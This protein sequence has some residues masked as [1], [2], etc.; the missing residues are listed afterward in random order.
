MEE[1][2]P[3]ACCVVLLALWFWASSLAHDAAER[4]AREARTAATSAGKD[5]KWNAAL[6]VGKGDAWRYAAGLGACEAERLVGNGKG[7]STWIPPQSSDPEEPEGESTQSS[8]ARFAFDR[9]ANANA[10]DK[11][12][13]AMML[14]AHPFDEAL[15]TRSAAGDSEA[16][17]CATAAA[18]G[19]VFYS[20]LQTDGGFWPGDYG[21]P[22]FL[23]PGLVI[24]CHVCK[25]D[26]GAARRAAMLRYI[27]TH[28]Q[29]GDGGWGMHIEGRSTV[30]GSVLNYAAARLLG[31]PAADERAQRGRGFIQSS[32]GAVSAPQ[33]AK[34]WLATLGAY[35]W[36][37]VNPT[38]PELWLLPQWFPFHP[39]KMWCHCRMVY[40]PMSALFGARY[41]YP[42]A[43][44]DEVVLA[45]REEL[46]AVDA[47]GA[48]ADI[49]WRSFAV[50]ES[51]AP[52][53]LF[54]PQSWLMTF[55]NHVLH[56]SIEHPLVRRFLH[57]PLHYLRQRALK[58]A[59]AYIHAEDEHTNWVDIGP[60]SKAF[61]LIA[62]MAA[63]G[64]DSPRFL[65]HVARLDDYLWLAEDGLK[66]QG[67]N[68]SMF[69]DTCFA[70]HA[71]ANTIVAARRPGLGVALG[72]AEVGAMEGSL[73]RAAVFVDDM[74]VRENVRD[75]GLFFRDGSDGGWP[76]STRDHGWPI[77]DCTA[78]GIKAALLLQHHGHGLGE[79]RIS[80]ARIEKAVV[81]ILDL[82]NV[83]TDHGWA[84]YELNRGYAWYEL[85][86]PAQVF[87]DIMI[88]YSYVECSSAAVQSLC[89]F[90]VA[91]P[92][93]PLAARAADAA[94]SG[95]RFI[96]DRQRQDG[97]WCGSWAVCFTYAGWFA[98]EGIAAVATLPDR[99]DVDA[100]LLK[101]SLA[102]GCDF[103]LL[104][105]N[106][107]GGWGE[108]VEACAK[109]VWVD[110]PNGSQAVQ[111]AWALLALLRAIEASRG[112][113]LE[114]AA[115]G[116]ADDKGAERLRDAATKAARLLR[117]RQLPDGD[118]PQESITGIFNKSCSI[119][120]TA[121][122]NVF[123]M[124]ALA[125]YAIVMAL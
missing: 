62:T 81:I 53:D 72:D 41:V 21:G 100:A 35:E 57:F 97:S 16:R 90:A 11:V 15:L 96:L 37:G 92:K 46:Y 7:R 18:R 31:L 82:Q 34:F 61:H 19:S 95:S 43:E 24:A 87:G 105:Q 50:R 64:Q 67:Y 115:Q 52:S 30:F 39:G 77:S 85:L 27:M 44:A 55:G 84:S 40:L 119:T 91:F 122:R 69:W 83:T 28:Q 74:Q 3:T 48:Y 9:E 109:E 17:Q 125:R 32:G 71:V 89:E 60:V 99:A 45:L 93:S 36:D 25:V 102:K 78:E 12:Y 65:N 80:Q 101:R 5:A 104:K 79:A 106:S 58:F 103:L 56:N 26:L 111:T 121:Y 54:N 113:E 76:F 94:V 86:N 8:S 107:D 73:R 20:R 51:I 108:S 124:W 98:V 2:G 66:M 68:G 110:N 38:P 6:P 29:A 120:Y 1:W 116:H 118:W 63:F 14:E 22:M 114:G 23:L 10:E 75:R 33:W 4:R 13:R 112:L 42:G 59:N 70:T 47:H 49:A 123:P 117:Q 88:D